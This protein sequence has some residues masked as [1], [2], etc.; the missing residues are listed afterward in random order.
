MTEVRQ[1]RTQAERRMDQI[2]GLLTQ[3]AADIQADP[4]EQRAFRNA[5]E[6]TGLAQAINVEAGDLRA[7]IAA[8]LHYERGVPQAEMA[9]ML[10]IGVVRVGQLTR[11]GKKRNGVTVP[12]KAVAG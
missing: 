12:R 8:R 11:L 5:T 6:L 9:G 3:I 10:G 7:W 1:H 4:D 2:R